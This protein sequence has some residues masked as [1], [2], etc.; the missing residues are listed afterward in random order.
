MI[1]KLAALAATAALLLTVLSPVPVCAESGLEVKDSYAQAGFPYQLEFIIEAAG[2]VDI[3]NIRLHYQ[4]EKD[5]FAKITSE[6]KLDSM[7]DSSINASW[8][9]DMTKT[10]GLPCGAVIKYWWTLEDAA[11]N[12]AETQV[13]EV[14]FD[15]ERYQWKSLSKGNIDI[16][17]YRGDEGFANEIMQ[18]AQQGLLRLETDT[19]AFLEKPV[20]IY[21]YASSSDLRG[22]MIFPQE[23]TGGVAYVDYGVVA[24]GIEP[25]NLDWGKRAVIHELAH[26]VTH[27]MTYNPYNSIPVWLNEG[28]SMYAEGE[29][30]AS[31]EIYLRQTVLNDSLISVHSLSSPFSAI[32]QKSY[33]SYAESLSIVQFLIDGYGH[34]KM[35]E[36]LNV[37]KQG[38]EYDE[39]LETVYGFDTDGLD[40]LWSDYIEGVYKQPEQASVAPLAL[41]YTA[42]V[43]GILAVGLIKSRYAWIKR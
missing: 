29:M 40:A 7:P 42:A 18:A 10:G 23:W 31:F 28:L 27:Q 38:S 15:D 25:G 11:G 20:R 21:V 43:A 33:L 13:Y 4:L 12:T 24:I 36:L 17:W 30:Q 34:E 3:T 8:T 35:T 32:S 39:A 14:R 22:A 9:M 1:K 41:L 19:G 6:V 5:S 26:L 37:F 16:Y 2:S